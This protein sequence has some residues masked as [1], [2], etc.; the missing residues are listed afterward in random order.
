MIIDEK[1]AIPFINFT[2]KFEVDERAIEYLS[3]FNDRI[4]LIAICGK[5]RT[6]KSYLLNRLMQYN[7]E[8]CPAEYKDV[9]ETSATLGFKV[10]PTVE[11]CTKGLWILK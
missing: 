2:N 5:Y 4:G 7:S 10:G 8:E 3:N 6:G 9:E 1:L 11:A